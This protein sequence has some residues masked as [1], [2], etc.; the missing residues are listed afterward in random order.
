MCGGTVVLMCAVLIAA[1]PA[2][3]QG[4]E[5]DRLRPDQR[6]SLHLILGVDC[7]VEEGGENLEL[8]IQDGAALSPALWEAFGDGPDQKKMD[9][10]RVLLGDGYQPWVDWLDR[11]GTDLFDAATL[12]QL[13][14]VTRE[15]YV[16]GTIMRMIGNQKAAALRALALIGGGEN[17]RRIRMIADTDGH[18]FQSTAADALQ[19]R[20]SLEDRLL[21][22]R[23]K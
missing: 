21:L 13:R 12:D 8:L 7:G 2:L 3:A 5:Y 14:S 9:R 16:N 6:A 15:E 22:L 23:A 20:G 18:E 4:P 19:D 10:L 1:S 11:R 17:L